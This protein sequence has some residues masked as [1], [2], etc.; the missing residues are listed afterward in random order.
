VCDNEWHH[1][2]V[3]VNFP[4]VELTVDGDKWEEAKDNPEIIDDWPLHK[5]VG[6]DTKVTVGACWQGE[7]RGGD[8]CGRYCYNYLLCKRLYM[9]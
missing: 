4:G 9:Y 7:E 6:I 8:Y 2:A 5:V 1:Y 3:S